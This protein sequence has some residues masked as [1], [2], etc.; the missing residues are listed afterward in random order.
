[1]T[2]TRRIA[3]E[4]ILCISHIAFAEINLPRHSSPTD[5]LELLH[6]RIHAVVA[7]RHRKIALTLRKPVNEPCRGIPSGREPKPIAVARTRCHQTTHDRIEMV[8]EII[9]RAQSLAAGLIDKAVV[10]L[11]KEIDS[12]V[13]HETA[14]ELNSSPAGSKADI[15]DLR[16]GVFYA[17]GAVV[18]AQIASAVIE[19]VDCVAP[20][21]NAGIVVIRAGSLPEKNPEEGIQIILVVTA[22]TVLFLRASL[23]YELRLYRPCTNQSQ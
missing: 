7:V 6:G 5:A 12:V 2:G 22:G 8:I 11:A 20:G 10:G 18:A 15:G 17:V 23:V 14:V 9:V 3:V 13:V 19:P 4:P 16:H 21:A 1:M